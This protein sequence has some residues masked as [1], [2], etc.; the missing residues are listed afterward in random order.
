ME[1][2][3]S[4]RVR[5]LIDSDVFEKKIGDARVEEATIDKREKVAE[6]DKTGR[7]WEASSELVDKKKKTKRL[8]QRQMKK[9]KISSPCNMLAIFTAREQRTRRL[10]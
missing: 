7:E 8:K 6:Y 10:L 9:I 2:P 1:A 5:K 3:L 4:Y